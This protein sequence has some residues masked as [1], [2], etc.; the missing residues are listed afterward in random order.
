MIIGFLFLKILSQN[1]TTFPV[2]FQIQIQVQ[3][4]SVNSF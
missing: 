3:I 4:Y 2:G 1:K